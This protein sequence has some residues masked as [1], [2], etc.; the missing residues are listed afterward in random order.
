MLL[1]CC[2]FMTT[3]NVRHKMEKSMIQQESLF[4]IPFWGMRIIN[5]EEKKKK[6]VKLL[7]SYPEEKKEG[8]QEFASNQ[9]S[10]T[11]L[12]GQFASIMKQELK[13][14]SREIE[15]EFAIIDIWSVSYDKGDYQST[16]NHSSVGL[17]GLLYLELPKD[18]PETTYIQPWTDHETDTVRYVEIPII[19]GDIVIVPSFVLHFS[20]PNKSKNKKRIIS[21]DMKII[22]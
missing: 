21:W 12:V 19:E 2:T 9:G 15:K 10:V 13:D 18:S 3:T 17:S 4:N 22:K 5:F 7:E 6:L 8:M 16:H 1:L 11:G 14:F 20:K